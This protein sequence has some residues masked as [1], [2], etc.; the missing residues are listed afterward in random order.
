MEE[1]AGAPPLVAC[2]L[3]IG[4]EQ[5]GLRWESWTKTGREGN[6]MFSTEQSRIALETF[7]RFGRNCADTIAELGCP[8]RQTPRNWWY[9]YEETGEVPLARRERE[10]RYPEEVRRE[11]VEHYLDHGRRLSRTMRELG[12]PK[13]REMLAD[14]ADEYAPGQRRCRGPNPRRDPV[15]VGKKV[16]VVA[17]LEARTGPA[18]EVAEKYGVP[19]TAPYVWRREIIGDD[20]GEPEGEGVPVSREY[21]DLPDDVG[22]PRDVPRRT[23]VRLGLG[24]RQATLETVEKGPGADPSCLTNAERAAM[25]EAL[26]AKHELWEVLPVVGMAKGSY[27][28]ARNAQAKS[29]GEGRAA[30]REAVT[31]A[32]EAGGGTC[33]YRR[34]AAVVDAG[35]WTVRGIAKDEGP[36][37]RTAE[38]ERCH[39]SCEGEVSAAPPDLPRDERGRR[40]LR[41]SKPNEPWVTGVTGSRIPAGRACLSPV[42]DRFDG[43]PLGR[44][45]PASPDAEMADSSLLGACGRLGEGDHP[46]T[47]PDRGGYYR[48]PGW[49]ETC[50]ESGPVRPTSGR[51]CGPDNVGREGLFGRP[52]IEL[53]YGC[54]WAVITVD[55]FMTMLDAYLRWYGD[56]RTKSDLDHRSPMRYRRDLGLAA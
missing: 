14:R 3:S 37:A 42:V 4:F 28:Y 11:A 41:A 29:E 25:V 51:G 54:D 52:E 56:V 27:E 43:M 32:L 50:D 47:R 17:E 18:A 49:T 19:R 8:H 15:P 34:V 36:V 10:P 12:Y 40:H 21:D 53:F 24:V 9:E 38:K 5:K 35:E 39:S 20:G 30:S 48:W 26:R 6:R 46:K 31:A 45:T 1:L 22:Q 2:V 16:Q 7:V 33:G 13:S 55:E 44:S 23:R